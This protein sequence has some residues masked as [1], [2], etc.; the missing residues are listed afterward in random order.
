M[1]QQKTRTNSG[2]QPHKLQLLT[3]NLPVINNRDLE[4][5]A[6]IGSWI[7]KLFS[8]CFFFFK[9]KLLSKT[10]KRCGVFLPHR[11]NFAEYTAGYWIL[12]LETLQHGY[13]GISS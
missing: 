13:K 7:Y 4:R 1:D 9:Y 5:N 12:R 3:N 11:L 2:M 6:P 8:G 10:P